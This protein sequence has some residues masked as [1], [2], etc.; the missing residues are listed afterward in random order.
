MSVEATRPIRFATI[1]LLYILLLFPVATAG[2]QEVASDT[3]D[4]GQIMDEDFAAFFAKWTSE[5]RYGS[6]LVDHLPVVPGIPTPKE[7]L[8]HHIGETRTL[9][10][11]EDI[12]AYY[13]ALAE[14]SPRVWIESIGSSDEGRDLVVVWVSSEEN[15][16][17][18]EQ[19]RENLA[20]LAD[21]RGLSE[22]EVQ[23]ILNTTNPNYHVMGGLHSGETGAP[24]AL[25]EMVYRLAT[26][27]SPFITRIRDNVFVSVTPVADPDGR[28]RIVDWYYSGLERQAELDA[29]AAAKD[30]ITAE[31]GDT[32]AAEEEARPPRRPS[33]PYWGKY[34]LHDNNRD[35]NL[36]QVIV[37]A[38][39]DWYFTAF[40]PIMHDCHE[41]GTLLYTYSGG[42]PQNPNLDPV[43]FGELSWFSNWEMTQMA[44]WNMPG[45]Y[46]HA[47][48]DAWSPG[49]LGSVVYN[50]NGLMR[51]YET[52]SPRDIDVDSL[53][54]ARQEEESSEGEEATEGEEAAEEEEEEADSVALFRST[55]HLGAP[56]GRGGS[57]AREWYRGH[58]V[59][60]DAVQTFTR[61]NNVN[62]IQ[63]G[64][65]SAIQLTAMAPRTILENFYI[66]SR[67]SIEEGRDEPPFGYVIPVQRDMTRVTRL[68]E[69]IRAQGI[70][71]GRLN[72]ELELEEG[73]FPAGSFLIKLDQP[74]GRLAKNLLEVQH[75][76]DPELRT[77]DDSGWTMG[78]AFNA[79]VE[80]VG[81]PS[82]LEA[83]TTTYDVARFEGEV[84]GDGSASLVVAHLGSTNMITFRYRLRDMDMRITEESFSAEGLEFP[85]GS[86]LM[87]G[88]PEEIEGARA[89]VL[90]LGLTAAALKELPEVRSHDGDAPRIAIYTEW[91]RTQEM[92]WYRHAFDQFEIPFD[93]I[94]KERVAEGSLG[95]QYDVI[96]MAAQDLSRQRVLA[97]PADRPEP[98]QQTEEY[99]YL[100]MYGS[101]PDMTGGFGAEGVEA[102]EE[103]LEEGGTLI[104]TAQAV[105]FPI[106][107][108]FAR[109][110]YTE[111][112]E[113]VRAQKPLVQAVIS[114]MDHPVF[115][116][117]ADSIYPMKYGQG[118]VAFRVGVADEDRVLARYVGGESSVL[119]GL[120]TGAENLGGRAFAVDSRP[121]HNGGGRVLMFANNP[122]Y[123]WQNHGEFNLV[124]NSILN[125]NDAPEK[126]REQGPGRIASGFAPGAL[127]PPSSPSD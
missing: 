123:R 52:Q 85:A 22:A 29:E 1:A 33:V 34:V 68:L 64:L 54:A 53:R 98:Y 74:Y 126:E 108:G 20:R 65:L 40:P 79:E 110:V 19:N 111:S 69:V 55:R 119:S 56:T 87:T 9:T 107:F 81:D 106:E 7:V 75:Y 94:Y 99:R 47:F 31:E 8:G 2:A 82:V 24:E 115:Y 127:L 102:F 48:M 105:S 92:G 50:H 60:D 6:P 77:Y 67:N 13:R 100:G 16:A 71:V 121:A 37:R 14:A 15:L 49:Y 32:V 12:L 21:P 80:E 38:L 112:P 61:R 104:A 25:M 46:T 11:Y 113:D 4:P 51:M 84:R 70:E 125:W 58:P 39:T 23:R 90:D 66:K 72:R 124:F 10:Y 42:P 44:K 83:E 78:Y 95:S 3:R 103:F 62:Y 97:E 89:Q 63:T 93:L 45:V 86:F 116:G 30:S 28:D 59:P 88:T 18:L 35:I 27:T 36:S 17:R 101:T 118:P 117:F 41:S 73:T 114:D 43:L 76:P 57:Q 26:E 5:P 96:L 120:M 91:Q 122:I 109:T